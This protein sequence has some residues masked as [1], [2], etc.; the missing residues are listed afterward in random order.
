MLTPAKTRQ[1]KV[2]HPLVSREDFPLLRNRPELVYLDSAATTQKPQVVIDAMV[3]FYEHEYASVHR[4]IYDLSAAATARY[5]AIRQQISLFT[6][7]QSPSEIIFT[8]NATGALN[9]AAYLLIDHI[10][11]GDEIIL[12]VAEH[13]S[14]LLPWQRLAQIKGARLVWLTPDATGCFPLDEFTSRLTGRTKIVAVGHVSNVLGYVAPLKTIVA[15]AHRVGAQV[16]VDAAQSGGHL[17]LDVSD[18]GAD[19][20][21]FSGH[22]TYGPT[23]TGWLYAKQEHLEDAEPQLVGGGTIKLVTQTNTIWHEV[24]WRFEA[25][26][27]N[28][29]G[30]VGLSAAIAWL[31]KLGLTKIWKHE[32]QITQYAMEKLSMV[33]GLEFYG[34][35][36]NT[37]DRAGILSFSLSVG[38]RRLH[39]HDIAQVANGHDVAVRG[40]HHCAQVLLSAL[41]I[42]DVTR[43][44][45]GCHTTMAD[46]DRLVMALADVSSV[47][48]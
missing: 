17:S 1:P 26:T 47:F 14:N 38:G 24:P 35:P 33:D 39:S 43:A 25:G 13:H 18:I 8:A 36:L 19:Y 27:P 11:A 16:V 40:G 31:Q 3:S 5:E 20:V 15:A 34:P 22:K 41:G 32:Q 23:G 42:P 48:D 45:V 2:V 37:K 4:G 29:S 6:G 9:L 10:N 7:A 21:A 12:T 46:I 28:I 30:I 44:S